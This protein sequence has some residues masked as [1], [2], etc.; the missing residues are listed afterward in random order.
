[1]VESLRNQTEITPTPQEES[2]VM[3]GSK[4][5]LLIPSAAEMKLAQ[6]GDAS[7]EEKKEE[8]DGECYI[9]FTIMVEPV[10]LPCKHKF[11]RECLRKFF[12]HKVEC[13]MCRAVP[14]PTWRLNV[15]KTL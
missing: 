7:K 10:V 15:D 13:P 14:P 9:C 2:K 4:Q 8:V 6:K 1:M 5:E 3:G 11:C 12:V